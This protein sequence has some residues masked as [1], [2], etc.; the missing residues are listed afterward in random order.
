MKVKMETH[1]TIQIV[2][3]FNDLVNSP[4]HGEVNALCWQ[5]EL[6]G[7]FEEIVHRLAS[8]ENIFEVTEETLL[9]LDLSD[10]GQNARQ[11]ILDDLALL[12]AHGAMPSL[13]VIK[14]YERDE[15]NAI[16]PTD[17]YSFHVDSSPIGSDTFL[18]TYFGAPS[19]ILPNTQAE[20]KVMVPA[21]RAAMEKLNDKGEADLELF[22]TENFYDLHYQAKTNASPIGL[23]IG[24]IWRLATANPES[25]V[26]PCIHRA[27][28]EKQGQPRLLLIC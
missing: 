10:D 27:P 18:C 11:I 24:H 22:I 12:K 9:S 25:K 13:N 14:Y 26:L 23:G 16:F 17:V 19:E 20:Q 3:N 8:V 5:R 1:A 28:I 6:H 15:E 7:N 2:S 21:V 4:F